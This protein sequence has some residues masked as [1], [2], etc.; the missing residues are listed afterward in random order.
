M[1]SISVIIPTRNE[2]EYID[3]CLESVRSAQL[4]NATVEVLI[5]DGMS[6]DGTRER[7]FEWSRKWPNVRI[8][9]N[10]KRI[11]PTAMNIGVLEARGEFIVRL[12]AHSEYPPDYLRLCLETA[13]RTNADNVGG[14]LITL[15][16]GK[17][18]SAAIVQALTTHP[19]GVGNSCFRI[20]GKQGW[21]DTVP[22]GCFRAQVFKKVGLFDERLERNQDYEFNRRIINNGGR[23]WFNP[24]LK[25]KYYNRSSVRGLLQQGL[26]TGKWN[27]WMWYVAYYTFAF[28]HLV[29][30]LFVG[31]VL[32]SALLCL[33]ASPNF[34]LSL[35]GLV[36]VP[37]FFLALVAASHQAKKFG[38]FLFPYL[39]LLWF[40]YHFVYGFGELWGVLL[41]LIRKASVQQD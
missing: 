5:V 1:P 23:I 36:I 14:A 10:P 35:L 41:L 25:A 9:D 20:N 13:R 40:G 33:I 8:L 39:P 11:V 12:D 38:M 7:L 29:P 24:H 16:R 32:F 17:N 6:E 2:L 4:G 3:R 18:R 22:F 21:S 28:R 31:S 26:N 27:V 30:L 19:F 15:S 34:G 37:Y